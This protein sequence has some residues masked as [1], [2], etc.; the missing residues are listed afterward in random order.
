MSAIK[1]ECPH[2]Q[3]PME[4]PEADAFQGVNC[5]SCYKFFRM[6]IPPATAT[7]AE[8]FAIRLKKEA[9]KLRTAADNF[10]GLALASSVIGI[11]ILGICAIETFNDSTSF[12]GWL[13]GGALIGMAFWFYLIAQI[14]HIRANTLK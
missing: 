6:V 11:L 9:T 7:P 12:L 3:Q 5:P 1:I 14:I 2:C 10:R 8:E 4:M 13:A